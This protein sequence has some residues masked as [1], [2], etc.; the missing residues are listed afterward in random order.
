MAF[1]AIAACSVPHADCA[2]P[3][4]ARR[5]PCT[6]SFT[7]RATAHKHA[8]GA[9]WAE[10]RMLHGM[11]VCRL[12][13]PEAD[14]DEPSG[15]ELQHAPALNSTPQHLTARSSTPQHA[16]ASMHVRLHVCLRVVWHSVQ[17]HVKFEQRAAK[18]ANL[19]QPPASRSRGAGQLTAFW[20]GDMLMGGWMGASACVHAPLCPPSSARSTS[21]S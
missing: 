7:H 14:A 16:M 18:P 5:D 6:L 15:G 8:C 4:S 12:L 10:L 17:S 9:K 2:L 13:R 3:C 19:P 20:L 1:G 21:C 11:V